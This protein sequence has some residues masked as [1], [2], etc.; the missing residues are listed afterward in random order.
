[1][2]G[3]ADVVVTIRAIDQASAVFGHAG[4]AASGLGSA[5]GNV[6]SIA[7]GFVIGQAL[8]QLPG[9]LMDATKAAADEEKGIARP[10]H[11][12]VLDP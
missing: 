11:E 3:A 10:H 8:F 5:I 9:L 1:M 7:S 2:A 6:A 4:R 12:P